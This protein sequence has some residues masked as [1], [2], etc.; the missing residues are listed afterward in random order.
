MTQGCGTL[1]SRVWEVL[2]PGLVASD[3]LSSGCCGHWECGPVDGGSFCLC[4]Y[5]SAFPLKIGKSLEGV[6]ERKKCNHILL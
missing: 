2:A 3:E 5:E 4:F 1:H 6:G